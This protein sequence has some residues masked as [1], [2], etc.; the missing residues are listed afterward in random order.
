MVRHIVMFRYRESAPQIHIDRFNDAFLELKTK[1]PGIIAI[2]HSIV[3]SPEEKNLVFSY[4]FLP[5]FQ[6]SAARD[7]YIPH[8][9]HVKFGELLDELDFVADAMVVN[10]QVG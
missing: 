3:D 5:T 4:V 2:E 9:N 1:R 6:N 7:A 8:P 10:Y